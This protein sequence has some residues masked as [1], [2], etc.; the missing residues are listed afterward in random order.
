MIFRQLFEPDSSTYTYLISCPD[1]GKTALIDP[2]LD[3]AQRDVSTLQ[4]MGLKLDYSIDTHIHADHLTGARGPRPGR[5][6]LFTRMACLPRKVMPRLGKGQPPGFRHPPP[7][8]AR[9]TGRWRPE[10][11]L[12]AYLEGRRSP[13]LVSASRPAFKLLD[14]SSCLSPPL[15]TP[16]NSITFPICIKTMM[17]RTTANIINTAFIAIY[18]SLL[19]LSLIYGV[20]N[21]PY[22]MDALRNPD[23]SF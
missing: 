21:S 1:S 7:P 6:P 9:P 3:T 4:A 8:P 22:N 19:S 5:R 2:V 11:G 16:I 13:S 10:T 20:L 23:Q 12:Q 14:S 15:R 17:R 18:L